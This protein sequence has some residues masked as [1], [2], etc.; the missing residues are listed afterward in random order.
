ML[1]NARLFVVLW[2]S[3]LALRGGDQKMT[4]NEAIAAIRSPGITGSGFFRILN[5]FSSGGLFS[6]QQTVLNAIQEGVDCQN[7]E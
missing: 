7:L 1:N 2:C 4:A 5:E 3:V 6:G